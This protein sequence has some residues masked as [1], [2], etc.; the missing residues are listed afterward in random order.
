MKNRKKRL[1]K[2][3]ESLK[4]QIEIHKIKKQQAEELDNENL[5][6]YYDKEI[7]NLKKAKE[8]KEEMLEK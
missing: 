8:Q 5:V 7:D 2:S 1:K 4:E 6:R 3:V